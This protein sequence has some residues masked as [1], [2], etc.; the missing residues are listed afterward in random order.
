M[1]TK[2]ETKIDME[3][4]AIK[5]TDDCENHEAWLS[6]VRYGMGTLMDN[7]PL[8]IEIIAREATKQ[9]ERK[10]VKGRVI[11][12]EARQIF[13]ELGLRIV[14]ALGVNL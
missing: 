4:F 12:D 8:L 7:Q 13:T 5:L 10:G 1:S 11:A 9:N 14:P 2:P 6:V 3:N